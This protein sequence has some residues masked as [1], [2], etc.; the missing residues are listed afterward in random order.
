MRIAVRAEVEGAD[1]LR[2]TS[3]IGDCGRSQHPCSRLSPF[4]IC[5]EDVCATPGRQG[6]T[7]I[8]R[9]DTLQVRYLLRSLGHCRA[10][11]SS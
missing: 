2:G 6:L 8:H 3:E 9:A 7:L 10:G 11:S 4:I 5:S 1:G